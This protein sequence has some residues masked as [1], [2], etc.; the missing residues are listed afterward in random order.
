MNDRRDRP[1]MRSG[2]ETADPQT[3]GPDVTGSIHLPSVSS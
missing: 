2:Y 1:V 3:A